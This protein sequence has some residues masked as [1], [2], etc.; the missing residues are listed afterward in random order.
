MMKASATVDAQR[1]ASMSRLRRVWV[2]QA[3][4][5]LH[6]GRRHPRTTTRRRGH[7]H[8]KVNGPRAY[9]VEGCPT[10]FL[11]QILR[12]EGESLSD[13]MSRT[14][15]RAN[16]ASRTSGPRS[17]WRPPYLT[18]SRFPPVQGR[19]GNRNRPLRDSHRYISFLMSPL[20][21]TGAVVRSGVSLRWCRRSGPRADDEA[22]PG[23]DC[24]VSIGV[25]PS[26]ER[27]H[28]PPVGLLQALA[29][30]HARLPAE[31]LDPRHVQELAGRAV[32]HVFVEHQL[33][34]PTHDIGDELG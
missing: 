1:A 18:P 26:R 34:V 2:S 25:A 11:V 6:A 23:D 16:R 10:G 33:T 5:T 12:G 9:D 19:S 22:R 15:S 21:A 31:R 29:Q 17:G 27:V 20:Q 7:P 24:G 13:E 30:A 4:T 3:A 8:M 32:W 14:R 28:V